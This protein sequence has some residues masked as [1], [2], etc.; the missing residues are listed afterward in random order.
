MKT[1][2]KRILAISLSIVGAIGTIASTAMGLKYGEKIKEYKDKA[3]SENIELNKKDMVLYYVKNC[4]PSI[5]VCSVTAASIISSQIINSRVETG[6]LA[7]CST[8]AV[9]YKK[10]K[11]K[12]QKV[13]GTDVSNKIR[14]ELVGENI[15][16]NRKLYECKNNDNGREWFYL[17]CCDVLFKAKI[18]DV[19]MAYAN[20]NQ[21]MTT[22][23]RDLTRVYSST[24]LDFLKD[25]NAVLKESD[26]NKLKYLDNYGWNADYLEECG[27][28]LNWI[29]MT[30][31]KHILPDG[32]TKFINISVDLDPCVNPTC[33]SESMDGSSMS[34]YRDYFDSE[35]ASKG[36]APFEFKETSIVNSEEELSRDVAFKVLDD[37]NMSE[38]I[39]KGC[40]SNTLV[41]KKYWEGEITE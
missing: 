31:E 14:N 37:I 22:V 1:S 24:L 18:E 33:T 28:A 12:I 34:N 32:N 6:L 19:M 23:N 29:R 16:E 39:L 27:H 17:E 4:W 8:L 5:A 41:E 35:S 25:S 21:R 11:N 26:L 10:Y 36:T 3:K 20:L 7:A 40:D 15:N 9:G 38:K 2:S 30:F 13:L